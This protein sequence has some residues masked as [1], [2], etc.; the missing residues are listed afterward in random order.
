MQLAQSGSGCAQLDA[1]LRTGEPQSIRALSYS[2]GLRPTFLR[3][4]GGTHASHAQCSG[5]A[6]RGDP[7][8]ASDPDFGFGTARD[9]L[10]GYQARVALQ[11]L[12]DDRMFVRP[13]DEE[14]RLGNL[15]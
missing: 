1:V 2:H 6:R 4:E 14:Q 7:K 12:L 5:A 3:V 11:E 8:S 10:S 15:R 13:C 9:G